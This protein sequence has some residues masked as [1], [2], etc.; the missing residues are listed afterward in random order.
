MSAHIRA[1]FGGIDPD[2]P[3]IEQNQS[4]ALA[5]EF[6]TRNAIRDFMKARGHKPKCAQE[7]E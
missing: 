3:L 1:L 5:A 7:T 2:N 6:E 4:R